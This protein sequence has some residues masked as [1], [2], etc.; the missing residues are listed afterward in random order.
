MPS[1][2]GDAP[3]TSRATASIS[4]SAATLK[5]VISACL[6][7]MDLSDYDAQAVADVLVD[8]NLRGLDGH[9]VSRVPIYMARLRAGLAGGTEHISL[10][11]ENGPLCRLDAGSALGPAAACR[12]VEHAMALAG[13]YGIGLVAAGNSTHF[14]A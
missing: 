14:G 12:G 2:E 4:V 9:G 3:M 5:E 7:G 10:R 1:V 8:A 6:K 13:T 11:V